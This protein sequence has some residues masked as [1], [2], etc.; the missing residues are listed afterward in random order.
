MV[1]PYIYEDVDTGE[2]A[3]PAERNWQ[4]FVPDVRHE[5]EVRYAYRATIWVNKKHAA[6]QVAVPSSDT[7]AVAVTTKRGV[8]LIVSAYDVKST[9]SQA[10]NEERLRG[11]LQMIKDAYDGVKRDG[12]DGQVDLLL[13]AD[14]N[15]HHE[16]WGG[17]QASGKAGRT[18]EAEAVIDFMQENAL[19]SLLPSGAVIWEHYNGSTCS[20][21]DILLAS[22]N[23]CEVCE[24]CGIHQNDHGSDHK[25]IRAHFAMDTTERQ[26]KRRKRMYEKA[27]WKKIR[28]EVSARFADDARFH[29]ISAKDG[30][31]VAV[32]SLEALVNEIL[33]EHVARA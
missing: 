21:I 2:P 20:T 10:A 27:D 30:L 1:E 22:G 17:A 8:A 6:Q 29:A 23:L 13:C 18:D 26:E 32:D 14:F 33:E 31:E 24:Y 11:K 15:C 28:E 16:L 12:R 25:A 9:E 3:F 4:L 19:T 7:V 5:G